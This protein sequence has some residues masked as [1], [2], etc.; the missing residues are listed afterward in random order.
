MKSSTAA[1]D[2]ERFL[3]TSTG[4]ES[5]LTNLDNFCFVETS[6]V[7]CACASHAGKFLPTTIFSL[8]VLHAMTG[9]EGITTR[10]LV[11]DAREDHVPRIRELFEAVFKHEMSAAHWEW[12]YG[13]GRGAGVIVREGEEIV[14]YFGGMERRI[15]FKG[16]PAI[17]F[18]SGDSM[19]AEKHRGTLSKK[20]PF[21]LSVAAFQDRY[22]GYGRPYLISYGFPNER[23][24]RLA[25][26]L[27]MYV[28]IGTLVDV[29]WKAKIT[30]E[31]DSEE[32]DFE[33]P[34]HQQVLAQLWTA[35]AAQFSDRAIGVRDLNYLR[36]RYHEHPALSYRLHLVSRASDEEIV[37][38]LVTRPVNEKLM[39]V[40]IVSTR[41]NVRNLISFGQQLASD[42]HC[43]EMFGWLTQVDCPLLAETG[44][45]IGDTPLRLPF[46]VYREGLNPEEI[47]DKW[48]FMCGDSDFL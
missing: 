43:S 45:S 3:A 38:L 22:L 39:L 8:Q 31:F 17:A 27:G 21:F 24:M 44:V 4:A 37:G 15:I 33:S 9:Y 5:Q 26:H 29:S 1:E 16:E 18:Q 34:R 12:K 25:E 11:E 42:L 6:P 7:A 47:R 20:G 46:G 41:D 19:V 30:R 10:W 13:D 32:F 40:D 48:F 28:E 23:A 36:H 2:F 14:S 35:M